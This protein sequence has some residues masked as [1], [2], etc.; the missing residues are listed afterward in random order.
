M[1]PVEL[2]SIPAPL[3]SFSLCST[4]M[5]KYMNEN[6]IFLAV[7]NMNDNMSTATSHEAQTIASPSYNLI[8][9]CLHLEH[10][11]WPWLSVAC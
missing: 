11:A 9:V 5:N 7:S 3:V 10:E 4:I 6:Y 8:L 1:G 2:R